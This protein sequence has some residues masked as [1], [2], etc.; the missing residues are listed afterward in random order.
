MFQKNINI[1]GVSHYLSE[2]A[3]YAERSVTMIPVIGSFLLNPIPTLRQLCRQRRCTMQEK[4]VI[5]FGGIERSIVPS[6]S[7]ILIIWIPPLQN[8][9][10]VFQNSTKARQRLLQILLTA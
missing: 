10:H 8:V 9:Q 1:R 5:A 6:R 7:E 3:A 2:A 4:W